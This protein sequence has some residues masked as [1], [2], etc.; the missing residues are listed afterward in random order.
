MYCLFQGEL[1][2]AYRNP[3]KE[4]KYNKSQGGVKEGEAELGDVEL[5]GDTAEESRAESPVPLRWV[6]Q[7]PRVTVTRPTAATTS[8]QTHCSE[9]CSHRRLHSWTCASSGGPCVLRCTVHSA[10]SSQAH[11]D[12]TLL[13][14]T[15][16]R[17]QPT[18]HGVQPGWGFAAVT[19]SRNAL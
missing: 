16:L 8:Q 5:G 9:K 4:R 6:R 18:E 3:Q 1:K 19:Q 14:S 11:A 12:L 7:Q 15:G 13:L 2:A 17:H 10:A